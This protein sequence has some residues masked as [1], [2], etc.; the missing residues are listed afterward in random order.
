M[1]DYI[2][3]AIAIRNAFHVQQKYAPEHTSHYRR[4]LW[5]QCSVF[6]LVLVWLLAAIHA[7]HMRATIGQLPLWQWRI[8]FR[9]LL[10]LVHILKL[11]KLCTVLAV[12]SAVLLKIVLWSVEC[13][14]IALSCNM[15]NSATNKTR[16]SPSIVLG[17]LLRPV[18][19]FVAW[20]LTFAMH[21][22]DLHGY[23]L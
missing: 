7:M 21:V 10:H 2:C 17:F 23:L 9:L 6:L 18:L 5:S 13:V 1:H 3:K 15:A 14:L 16:N 22:I 19:A 12:W 8:I 4:W 11:V 20:L